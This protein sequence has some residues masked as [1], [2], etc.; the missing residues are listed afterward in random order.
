[1]EHGT[2]NQ[3]AV[4]VSLRGIEQFKPAGQVTVHSLTPLMRKK[5]AIKWLGICWGLAVLTIFLPLL[6][7]FLP[8]SFLI[9]G[10]FV[11]LAMYQT[12]S[13]VLPFAVPCPKCG[14]S[15]PIEKEKESW[16]LHDLCAQCKSE[17]TIDKA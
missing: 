1:M 14:A 11:A 8:P 10:P 13:E 5:R 2:T 4:Q 3:V 17:I 12:R 9:A 7:F 6:H 15:V 16:P